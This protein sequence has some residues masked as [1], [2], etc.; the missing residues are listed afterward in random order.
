MRY[1]TRV[2]EKWIREEPDDV[3]K[4]LS[5]NDGLEAVAVDD[6]T[7]AYYCATFEM[8]DNYRAAWEKER[9]RDD[10]RKALMFMDLAR[11]LYDASPNTHPSTSPLWCPTY[12]VICSERE[13]C[14]EDCCY[15]TKEGV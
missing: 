5:F 11:K 14:S 3:D 10:P 7:S 8:A 15:K 12:G 1:L 13:E 4:W 2:D 9:K 6:S